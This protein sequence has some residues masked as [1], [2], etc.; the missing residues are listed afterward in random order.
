MNGSNRSSNPWLDHEVSIFKR[1]SLLQSKWCCCFGLQINPR[2]AWNTSMG[3]CRK[4]ETMKLLPGTEVDYGMVEKAFNKNIVC[5]IIKM[6][7]MLLLEWSKAISAA[8]LHH[9]S[10]L[11]LKKLSIMCWITWADLGVRH[12]ADRRFL[13]LLQAVLV[14]ESELRDE[15]EIA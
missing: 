4:E 5:C 8:F 10:L 13:I 2:K 1:T 12:L 15:Q 11:L 9:S 3:P 7:K 6:P 14:V